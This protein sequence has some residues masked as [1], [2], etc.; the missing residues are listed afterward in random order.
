MESVVLERLESEADPDLRHDG[1]AD[2]LI[3]DHTD[4]HTA[5][6]IVA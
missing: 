1:I 5:E 4:N 3:E 2:A 6:P